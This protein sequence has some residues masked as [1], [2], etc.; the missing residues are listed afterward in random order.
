MIIK[1][2]LYSKLE[3]IYIPC[4]MTD[5]Y[6]GVMIKKGAM[7]DGGKKGLAH[8]VEH[9]LLCIP[10]IE[11]MNANRFIKGT[12]FLD[13]T[14]YVISDDNSLE[15]FI[16]NIELMSNI[17]NGNYIFK[18]NVKKIK[19]DILREFYETMRARE[20]EI[21]KDFLKKSKIANYL[22]IGTKKD[23][24]N[25]EFEDIIDFFN[26]NYILENMQL[27]ILGGE[28][29]W[30]K[31]IKQ[32][33]CVKN[34]SKLYQS[35]EVY[36]IAI[37]K[38][39]KF[40]VYKYDNIDE[41]MCI[42]TNICH[43][44]KL[45]NS[46]YK[47]IENV[48]L[49]VIETIFHSKYGSDSI[50]IEI[51]RYSNYNKILKIHFSNYTYYNEFNKLIFSEDDRLFANTFKMLI[52]SLNESLKNGFFGYQYIEH[53]MDCKLYEEEIIDLKSTSHFLTLDMKI[54]YKDVMEYIHSLG[55]KLN[56]MKGA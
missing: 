13:K 48:A 7:N 12:T 30:E 32:K 25:I 31:Y 34:Y 55:R 4:D 52:D 11:L 1:G 16:N 29:S 51:V 28:V 3:Y 27:C 36:N 17:V 26:S 14:S 15:N 33:F 42:Y 41:Y 2:R 9:M 23:I 8:F 43:S 50:F 54:I 10:K 53:I 45:I 22:P 46:Y 49:G 40:H 44:Y 18:D 56:R 5:I 39:D 6:V 35:S 47:N 20:I 19:N 38:R 37:V 24:L 21:E